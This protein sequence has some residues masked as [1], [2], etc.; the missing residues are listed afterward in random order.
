MSDVL[1]HNILSLKDRLVYIEH[2]LESQLK[3]LE[4]REAQW[5]VMEDQVED[6]RN[7]QHDMVSLNIG[8]EIFATRVETLLNNKDNLFY[9]IV[10]SKRFKLNKEIFFDR[11]SKMFKY[12]LEFLRTGH[13]NYKRFSD[14]EKVKLLKEA[15]YYGLKDIVEYIKEDQKPILFLSYQS[16]ASFITN[17]KTIGSNKLEDLNDISKKGG[18]CAAS[19]AWIIIELDNEW[20]FNHIEICG[21]N[22]DI[23]SWTPKTDYQATILTSINKENWK[24]VGSVPKNMNRDSVSIRL[25]TSKAKFIKVLS[26][27]RFGIGFLKIHKIK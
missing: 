21:Y 16:N 6:L 9:E 14:E 17:G 2:D 18:I 22:G 8:G 20:E 5:K 24:S 13:I 1:K 27:G 25:T 23:N 19:P 11:D 10:Q 26:A 4:L 15:E 12:I 7:K 3:K